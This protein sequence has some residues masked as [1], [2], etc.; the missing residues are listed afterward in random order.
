MKIHITFNTNPKTR[1]DYR[2]IHPKDIN[3]ID[4]NS[5]ESLDLDCTLDEV[6]NRQEFLLTCMNKLRSNGILYLYGLDIT[7]AA[8]QIFLGD[9]NI[10]EANQLIYS[11]QST[12]S[13]FR[14]LA[15]FGAHGYAIIQKNLIGNAY[16]LGVQKP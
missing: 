8:R 16:S 10:D 14:L 5:C 13:L 6:K 1:I 4:N 2:H 11:R 9:V 15:F 7:V 3:S 12:D